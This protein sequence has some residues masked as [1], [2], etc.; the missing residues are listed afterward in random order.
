M[1]HRR[2]ARGVVLSTLATFLLP[3][4]A[5]AADDNPPLRRNV[6]IHMPSDRK[7]L[8]SLARKVTNSI[9]KLPHR[10]SIDFEPAMSL[11]EFKNVDP[12]RFEWVNP[13]EIKAGDTTCGFLKARLGALPYISYPTVEVCK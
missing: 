4:L 3:Y 7:G 9:S 11:D 10:R 1:N 8:A 5:A 13:D 2:C 12:E 6:D